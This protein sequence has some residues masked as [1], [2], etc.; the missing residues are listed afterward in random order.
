M[1]YFVALTLALCLSLFTAYAKDGAHRPL[2]DSLVVH[3]S[4]TLAIARIDEAISIDVASIEKEVP[5]FDPRSCT[6]YSGGVEL[7]SQ[8]DDTDRNGSPDLLTF[9]TDFAPNEQKLI[10]LRWGPHALPKKEYRKRTQADMSIKVDYEFVNGKYAKGR[11][12]RIDSVRVPAVHVDHDGLFQHEGPTWESDKIGYRFYLDERNRTDIFGK[13]VADMVLNTAGVHDLVA[14]NNE[15]YESMLYWGMDNFKVG[16]SLGIGS[17]AMQSGTDVV[18]VSSTDSVFCIIA[19]N[20]PVRSDVRAVYYGWNVAGKKYNLISSYSITAGSRLTMCKEQI[21]PNPSNL[22]T[23][24]AKHENTTLVESTGRPDKGWQYFGLFGKQS[25]AGDNMGIAVFY[26]GSEKIER[27]ADNVSYL[28]ILRPRG[29]KLTYYF[30]AAW[31]Q[32][33]NGITSLEEFRSYL[34]SIAE[35]LNNPIR[36]IF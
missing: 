8:F 10:V 23:G 12:V 29:G 5:T 30:A 32:E 26:K 15:S 19:A 20:G 6:V 2:P 1:K 35:E 11:F 9:V 24:L 33:Q 22:C 21:S 34:K 18:T 17:L 27:R 14:N 28:V 4:N 36:V 3:A 16:T 13:K 25:R 31:Q 7:P